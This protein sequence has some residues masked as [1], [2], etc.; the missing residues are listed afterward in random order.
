MVWLRD[1]EK[2]LWVYL[3]ILTQ[4]RRVANGYAPEQTDR[5][6]HS[7]IKPQLNALIL[8]SPFKKQ[9]ARVWLCLPPHLRDVHT[10]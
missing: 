5:F 1:C 7:V 8:A 3:A 2:S 6:Q 4:Y 10:W 9:F